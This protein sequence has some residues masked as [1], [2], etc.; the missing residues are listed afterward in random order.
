M[1]YFHFF[2]L[3]PLPWS[4]MGGLV[5]LSR[6]ALPVLLGLF[7]WVGSLAYGAW[8]LFLSATRAAGG[9][10]AKIKNLLFSQTAGLT[11]KHLLKKNITN[12]LHFIYV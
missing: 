9:V 8:L 7:S 5:L 12:L 10:Q 3:P 2:A 6:V 4:L 11:L 1:N